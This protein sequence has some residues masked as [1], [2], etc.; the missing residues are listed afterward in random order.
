MKAVLLVILITVSSLCIAQNQTHYSIDDIRTI[1]KHYG[2]DSG[3]KILY[4][5]TDIS[6]LD[7]L[8]SIELAKQCDPVDTNYIQQEYFNQIARKIKDTSLGYKTVAVINTYNERIR[9][10]PGS[11]EFNY[12]P[13]KFFEI[14]LFQDDSSIVSYMQNGFN[15]WQK[16][17]DSL[18]KFY[19]SSFKRFF[20]KFRYTQPPV[21][22]NYRACK[23]NAYLFA[24][25]LNH[26]KVESF[27][28]ERIRNLNSELIVKDQQT[29]VKPVIFTLSYDTIQLTGNYSALNEIN[30]QTEPSLAKFRIYSDTNYCWQKIFTGNEIA[31]YEFGCS[32]STKAGMGEVIMAKLIAHDKLLISLIGGW[33]N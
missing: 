16:A 14:I 21:V 29:L 26:F 8:F 9:K 24:S 25:T 3:I 27:P 28:D 33:R 20:Q 2:I 5:H 19:P 18:R 7:T 17:T 6:F 23:K 4:P 11:H 22:E 12:I 1:T 13:A 15:K 31:L 10:F 30:F 32:I